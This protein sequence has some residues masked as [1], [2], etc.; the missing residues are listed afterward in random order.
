MPRSLAVLLVAVG[1]LAVAAPARASTA[2]VTVEHET[3]GGGDE[4][5][6]D[7]AADPGETNDLTATVTSTRMTFT[8]TGATVRPGPG[9]QADDIHTAVCTIPPGNLGAS[10]VE[11]G[12]GADSAT[13]DS[14]QWF[15][16]GGPGDDHISFGLTAAG[17]ISGDEGDDVL[18]GG[19][20]ADQLIGGAGDDAL[21]GNGGD[22]VLTGDTENATFSTLFGRDVLDGGPGTDLLDY[23]QSGLDVDVDLERP[24]VAGA[25]GEGDV[26]SGFEGIAGPAFGAPVHSHL[27]GDDGPNELAG[28]GTLDGRGGDD[29]IIAYGPAHVDA[30]AG[31]DNVLAPGAGNVVSC[32]PGVDRVEA[33]ESVR[34]APVIGLDCERVSR[35][36][37]PPY[38]VLSLKVSAAYVT[39][40]A[41]V[42]NP[43]WHVCSGGLALYG[44]HGVLYGAT[45]WR[46][47]NRPANGGDSV[48]VHVALTAHGQ[49]AELQH[50]QAIVRERRSYAKGGT[51]CGTKAPTPSSATWRI[52]L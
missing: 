25:P 41:T 12:D 6:V 15:I 43:N 22:D 50:R 2:S 33:N 26:I 27:S 38:D 44:P 21:H 4:V 9:C 29:R 40:I 28:A 19:A 18:D 48:Q 14:G 42:V 5:T 1:A 49:L 47:R 7:Y 16:G 31:K 10:T 23:S 17:L 52:V 3:H 51:I 11:L 24:E 35:H 37:N 13:A 36:Y 39:F 20:G 8:D 46:W 34:E 45:N 30:G 32:G